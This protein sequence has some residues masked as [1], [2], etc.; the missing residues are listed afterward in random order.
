MGS[1]GRA[2][3]LRHWNAVLLLTFAAV[4]K[5]SSYAI[6]SYQT[7][8]PLRSLPWCGFVSVCQSWKLKKLKNEPHYTQGALKLIKT[9]FHPRSAA[10]ISAKYTNVFISLWL[11]DGPWS[12]WR[13][14]DVGTP[15]GTTSPNP[16]KWILSFTSWLQTLCIQFY[17]WHTKACPS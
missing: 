15:R 6:L 8:G 14:T 13:F 1:W 7:T 9:G 12:C 16:G 3:F 2:D 11:G 10:G 5:D 4:I 17:Q